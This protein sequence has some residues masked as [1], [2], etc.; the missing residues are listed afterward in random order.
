MDELV[1]RS[2]D[3]LASYVPPLGAKWITTPER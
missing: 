3:K 2:L 1:D